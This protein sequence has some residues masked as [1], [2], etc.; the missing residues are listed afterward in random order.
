V[1]GDDR[2]HRLGVAFV[3]GDDRRGEDA[4]S[5]GADPL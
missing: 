1:E 4:A 5:G 3:E 2:R